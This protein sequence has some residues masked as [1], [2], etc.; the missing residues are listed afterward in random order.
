MCSQGLPLGIHI[1]SLARRVNDK[2]AIGRRIYL[3]PFLPK[4]SLT[5]KHFLGPYPVFSWK[6]QV[7]ISTWKASPLAWGSRTEWGPHMP[8]TQ[9]HYHSP[10]SPGLGGQ[11][12]VESTQEFHMDTWMGRAVP[13]S[14]EL[15]DNRNWAHPSFSSRISGCFELKLEGK[16]QSI[17]ISCPN[18]TSWPLIFG[19][20]EAPCQ[21]CL[22]QGQ[23]QHICL[24][25]LRLL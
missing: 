16:N 8:V 5:K 19:S 7:K 25:Q 6:L 13:S 10:A 15:D 3:S 11:D 2:E 12:W 14:W 24:S 17:V 22:S 21:C 1:F 18:S 9:D 20:V 4:F 23:L